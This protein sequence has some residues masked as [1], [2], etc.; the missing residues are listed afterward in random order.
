MAKKR[1]LSKRDREIKARMQSRKEWD[2]IL[3]DDEIFNV[4]GFI[5][6]L[7]DPEESGHVYP[8]LNLLIYY[9]VDENEN[10]RAEIIAAHDKGKVLLP[11][12]YKSEIENYF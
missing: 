12:K 10:V 6:R 8:F 2:L 4:I 11:Y 7:I 9:C 1:R 3:D 5:T